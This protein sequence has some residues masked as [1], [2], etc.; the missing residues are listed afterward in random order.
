M[1]TSSQ[2][3]LNE[4]NQ[5]VVTVFLVAAVVLL[6][7][8]FLILLS[9]LIKNAKRERYALDF[10]TLLVKLPKANEIKID[11]AE[12]MF[13]GLYSLKKGGLFSFLKPED[14][15]GFE[16]VGQ[17]EDIAF[18]VTCPRKIRDLVEKQINGAYPPAEIEEVDEVNIFGESGRVAFTPV[19]LDKANFYPIK[20]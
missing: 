5:F 13:T 9:I 6:V 17:K 3:L 11:A 1:Q 19:K 14:V 18:Y 15:I 2:M 20:T 16:I 12:Q 7:A 4:L 10:V 8:L